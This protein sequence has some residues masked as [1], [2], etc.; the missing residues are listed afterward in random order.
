MQVMFIVINMGHMAYVIFRNP[1]PTT[2][3]C[4]SQCLE[5]RLNR[6]CLIKDNQNLSVIRET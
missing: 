3:T 1:E 4:K 6:L 2:S 5:A